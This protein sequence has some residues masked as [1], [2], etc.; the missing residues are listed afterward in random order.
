MPR[1]RL[2]VA[3]REVACPYRRGDRCRAASRWSRPCLRRRARP[4][5]A[6]SRS[7]Q[8]FTYKTTPRAPFALSDML[9][10]KLIQRDRIQ[11]EPNQPRQSL[12]EDAHDDSPLRSAPRAYSS[13]SP[14]VVTSRVTSTSSSTESAAGGQ[15]PSQAW[16]TSRPS[17]ATFPKTAASSSNSVRTSPR[18]P[19]RARTAPPH[20]GPSSSRWAIHPGHRRRGRRHRRSPP[21]P[22]ARHRKAQRSCPG[23]SPAWDRQREADPPDQSPPK[24]TSATSASP[25]SKARHRRR[26]R[27]TTSTTCVPTARCH[28]IGRAGQP[29]R[30]PPASRRKSSASA[31]PP[32]PQ[33]RL[34]DLTSGTI[35]PSMRR[36]PAA[37]LVTALRVPRPTP[38][39]LR[40]TPS[41]I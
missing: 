16:R 9:D 6:N 37:A 36:P 17:S 8:L 38:P 10:A 15:P 27:T 29:P 40:L 18:R 19:Q 32:S 20:S 41:R 14:S 26:T 11:P 5:A 39:I 13:R 33:L 24:R 21:L 4:A 3:Y 31:R 1:S 22:A 12:D 34:G 23:S 7:T 30:P 35:R 2:S 25:S 28:R